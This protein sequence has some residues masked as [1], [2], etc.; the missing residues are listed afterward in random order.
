VGSRAAFADL[1]PS[2]SRED[3]PGP[4]PRAAR[5]IH[6]L[7]LGVA[8]GHSTFR[9]H[10]RPAGRR[11]RHLR[12]DRTG[13]RGRGGVR[14]SWPTRFR[15]RT[16]SR[17]SRPSPQRWK[18]TAA[19]PGKWRMSSDRPASGSTGPGRWRTTSSARRTAAFRSTRTR[20]STGAHQR[21]RRRQEQDHFGN[22]MSLDG[23]VTG[24]NVTCEQLE[25][26][27]RSCTDG[28]TTGPPRQRT[29]F[30][31]AR[32]SGLDPDGPTVLRPGRGRRRV[33]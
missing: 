18:P 33:D 32:K 20:R 1:H 14:R 21:R 19:G 3:R 25:T 22:S 4:G 2:V 30:R 8:A 17:R 27:A 28:C 13:R 23:F 5:R 7:H 11:H 6:R 10:R 31:D 24:P 26:V 15:R 16:S 9:Q 12:L 29:A